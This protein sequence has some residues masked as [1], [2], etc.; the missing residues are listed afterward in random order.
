MPTLNIENQLEDFDTMYRDDPSVGKLH[1]LLIG[2][3]GAGKTEC[4]IATAPKPVFVFSFDADGTKTVRDLVESRDVVVDRRYE[5][6]EPDPKAMPKPEAAFN[7]FVNEYNRLLVGGFFNQFATVV[8]DSLSTVATS[9]EWAILR[10]E[11][12]IIPS[13]AQKKKTHRG[14]DGVG[15][16]IQ[17]WTTYRNAMADL[18]R[19]FNTLPCHTIMTTHVQRDTNELTGKMERSIFVPGKAK[20]EIPMNTSEV[21][22]LQV[23]PETMGTKLK[24][25]GHQLCSDGVYRHLLTINDGDF[26]GGTRMGGHGKLSPREKPDIRAI[27]KKV[28]YSWEDLPP[29]SV[30]TASEATTQK[31]TVT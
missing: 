25:E 24:A 1:A 13:P 23:T 16:R 10:N 6:D 3:K 21:W 26:K 2:D 12:R 30:K 20:V 11:G 29:L 7:L 14:E 22:H 27:L 17:D 28:G 19:N 9:L 31:G 5:K 18:T 15:M 4:A 8:L